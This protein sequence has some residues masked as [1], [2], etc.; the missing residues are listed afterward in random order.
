VGTWQ[1]DLLKTQSA[2]DHESR[3]TTQAYFHTVAVKK[4]KHNDK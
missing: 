3:A 2:L 4:D 1:G